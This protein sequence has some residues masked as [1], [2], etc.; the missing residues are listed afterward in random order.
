MRRWY[1][2]YLNTGQV[3]SANIMLTFCLVSHNRALC[4]QCVA[5]RWVEKR[6]E[7]RMAGMSESE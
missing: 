3:A 5:R 7:V 2:V 1:S 4:S 6:S